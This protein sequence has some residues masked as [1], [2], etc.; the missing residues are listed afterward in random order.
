[1]SMPRDDLETMWSGVKA[2]WAMVLGPISAM[3]FGAVLGDFSAGGLLLANMPAWGWIAGMIG[4]PIFMCM[5]FFGAI[6]AVM[7]VIAIA[8]FWFSEMWRW[9]A[10][11]AM[12]VTVAIFTFQFTNGTGDWWQVLR[13]SIACV[14]LVGPYVI[15]RVVPVVRYR[16]AADPK[17]P[18]Q[19]G[20]R[21]KRRSRRRDG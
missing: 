10:W 6:L 21:R 13:V 17:R 20:S 16:R 15:G 4:L 18:V 2:A 14:V 9:E 19:R 12:A 7:L 8:T 11:L 1:M 5:T 3:L